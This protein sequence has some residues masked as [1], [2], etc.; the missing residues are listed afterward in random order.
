MA[1]KKYFKVVA[2]YTHLGKLV[3]MVEAIL[4]LKEAVAFLKEHEAAATLSKHRYY[5]AVPA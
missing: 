4:P 1:E 2:K 5:G 3:K